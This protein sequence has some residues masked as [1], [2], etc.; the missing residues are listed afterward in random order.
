MN[1][2]DPVT[3]DMPSTDDS[4]THIAEPEAAAG[5]PPAP[6]MPDA[7]AIAERLRGEYAEIAMIAAQAARLGID[8]EAADAL[9]R[10]LRPDALRQ[11]ILDRLAAQSEAADIVAIAPRPATTGDSP[12]VKRARERAAAGSR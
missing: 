10:G 7:H 1:T 4:A 9:R 8:I 12:I 6:P 2:C 3:D 11:T 5:R